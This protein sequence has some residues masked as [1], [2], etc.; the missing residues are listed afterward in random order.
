MERL[1]HHNS[2]LIGAQDDRG[3][4]AL[5]IACLVDNKEMVNLLLE[6]ADLESNLLGMEDKQG[7][8]PL[9]MAVYHA[10]AEVVNIMAQA[11]ETASVHAKMDQGGKTPLHHASYRG[12]PEIVEVI[13]HHYQPSQIDLIDYSEQAPLHIAA[14]QGR[15][16]VVST[17]LAHHSNPKLQNAAGFLPI[18]CAVWAGAEEA[19]QVLLQQGDTDANDPTGK[20]KNTCLHL[21]VIKEDYRMIKLLLKYDADCY[22]QDRAGLTPMELAAHVGPTIVKLLAG[23]KTFVVRMNQKLLYE[24]EVSPG[25]LSLDTLLSTCERES[26]LARD[27]MAVKQSHGYYSVIVSDKQLQKI[28]S[29][30]KE[31]IEFE[32]VKLPSISHIP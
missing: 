2:D 26:G 9:H 17:L 29:Q 20:N 4:S 27:E 7:Y 1:L 23:L 21:A 5:H 3:I 15:A 14:A 10:S 18:H 11:C 31:R 28:L 13:L 32:I 6:V 19:A 24:D 22:C 16:S 8:T 30:A 25:E 12:N